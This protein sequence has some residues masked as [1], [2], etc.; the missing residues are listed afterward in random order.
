[1]DSEAQPLRSSIVH[2]QSSS[3]LRLHSKNGSH[4]LSNNFANDEN[5]GDL[6]SAVNAVGH[7]GCHGSREAVE[8]F[9][10][11]V[12]RIALS[13]SVLDLAIE[14]SAGDVVASQKV[15]HE[16]SFLGYQKR[17]V[18][19]ALLF[20]RQKVLDELPSSRSQS[21]LGVSYSSMIHNA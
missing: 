10:F 5:V 19:R 21:R 14:R 3:L 13:E 4:V 1:M 18:F 11:P 6:L 15:S 12:V 7:F 8:G 17:D 2:K 16:D 20:A 9:F